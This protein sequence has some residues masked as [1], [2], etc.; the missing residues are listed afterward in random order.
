M[1][2]HK[3]NIVELPFFA[4]TEIWT[5]RMIEQAVVKS[6]NRK[7]KQRTSRFR[8]S[9]FRLKRSGIGRKKM[10]KSKNMVTAA[11]P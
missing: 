8:K 2:P 4:M 6:P 7:T 5:M 10:V 3:T 1:T 9:I 11:K